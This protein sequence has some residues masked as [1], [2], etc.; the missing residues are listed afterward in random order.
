MNF[1]QYTC[2]KWSVFG[3]NQMATTYH[4]RYNTFSHIFVTRQQYNDVTVVFFF[5]TSLASSYVQYHVIHIL[6]VDLTYFGYLRINRNLK[7]MQTLVYSC[8][9]AY[10]W[11]W[12]QFM[13]RFAKKYQNVYPN[14]Q[15]YV[16]VLKLAARNGTHTNEKKYDNFVAI[17][18]VAFVFSSFFFL[19]WTNEWKRRKRRK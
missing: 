17:H 5:V 9:H 6:T 19:N 11:V 14:Y 1:I 8:T 16:N 18:P 15:I 4:I 12:C 2:F 3:Q 13:P 10:G 7:Y